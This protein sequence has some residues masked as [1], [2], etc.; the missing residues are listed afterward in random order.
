MNG[1]SQ[2]EISGLA[3]IAA[4]QLRGRDV[5]DHPRAYYADLYGVSLRSVASWIKH[6]IVQ[7]PPDPPPLDDPMQFI[8]WWGRYMVHRVP[9]RLYEAARKV[10][11]AIPDRPSEVVASDDIGITASVQPM[12]SSSPTG[13]TGFL[14]T[15]LR[16]RQEE[17]AAHRRYKEAVEEREPNEGKIRVAQKN[18]MELSEYLRQLD[19]SAPEILRSSGDMWL[20]VDVIAELAPLH[21]DIVNG[22]RSL[23]RRF[24]SKAGIEWDAE[25]DRLFGDEVNFVF[26]ALVESKFS[27]GEIR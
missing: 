1:E 6:G 13:A 17:E 15:L 20:A 27:T 7:E 21:A 14:A 12:P 23:G 11:P 18:W 3:P 16:T 10:A 19:K 5:Y 9:D 22:V 26:R 4:K 2:P 24:A 25:R 8:A